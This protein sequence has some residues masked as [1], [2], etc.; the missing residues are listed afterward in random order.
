M[1]IHSCTHAYLKD[2]IMQCRLCPN[3]LGR[4]KLEEP[5]KQLSPGRVQTRRHNGK[6][7]SLVLSEDFALFMLQK[8]LRFG[9]DA[10]CDRRPRGLVRCAQDAEDA[11]Q[12]VR[13]FLAWKERLR[14]HHLVI[15]ATNAP[16]VD[17]STVF[18]THVQIYIGFPP[19]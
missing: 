3:S 4:G 17:R 11:F 16:H 9:R 7:L 1:N 15:N 6:V 5:F 13:R 14:N 18:N 8:G 2:F 12:L 19:C 10:E